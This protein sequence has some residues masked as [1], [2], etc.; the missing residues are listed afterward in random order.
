MKQ[1]IFEALKAK[2]TGVNANVLNRIADKLAKTVT[3]DEQVATAVAG[4]TQELIEV[5]ESYGDSR[6]TEAQQTAVAN[7]ESTRIPSRRGRSRTTGRN[8]QNNHTTRRGCSRASPSLG[9]ADYRQQQDADGTLEQDGR[10]A[11]NRNPQT[12]TFDCYRQVTRQ[13]PQALRAYLR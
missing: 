2:F 5:I 11:H 12:A 8:R 10:R 7:Y 13:S 4:V 3:T 6:A 1:K 9:T